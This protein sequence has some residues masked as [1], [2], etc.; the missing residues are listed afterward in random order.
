MT[1]YR[2]LDDSQANRT[3]HFSEIELDRYRHLADLHADASIAAHLLESAFSVSEAPHLEPLRERFE[4]S[5][6]A[7]SGAWRRWRIPRCVPKS[8]RS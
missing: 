4:S 7:L 8:A 6:A 1:G 5:A 3:D 2:S